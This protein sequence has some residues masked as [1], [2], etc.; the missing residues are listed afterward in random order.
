VRHAPDGTR[1][2][3]R[4]VEEARHGTNYLCTNHFQ[5]KKKR[6]VKKIIQNSTG[7][8]QGLRNKSDEDEWV[9][10]TPPRHR[11]RPPLL[12]NQAAGYLLLFFCFALSVKNASKKKFPK[13]IC[14]NEYLFCSAV[15]KLH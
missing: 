2:R 11:G 4:T 8:H 12:R 13:I 6:I 15:G 5:N 3:G 10:A 14:S 9:A 1:A 7:V